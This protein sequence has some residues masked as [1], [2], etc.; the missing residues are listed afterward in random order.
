MAEAAGFLPVAP[1]PGDAIRDR[2]H[3]DPACPICRVMPIQVL[4]L[5]A[6]SLFLMGFFA[7]GLRRDA[8][9]VA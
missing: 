4:A 8:F 9:C 1:G 7:S 3:P 6:K 2:D 5:P